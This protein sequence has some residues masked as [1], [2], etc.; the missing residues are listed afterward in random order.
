[1]S[2]EEAFVSVWQQAF[3]ENA[4]TVTLDDVSY[5][6][7]R[8]SRSKLREVDSSSGIQLSVGW[9]KTPAQTRGGQS[10]HERARRLCSFSWTAATLLGSSTA[11][12]RCITPRQRQE[13]NYFAASVTSL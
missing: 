8:T 2:L 5:P 12:L 3:A 1:M 4:K 6:I 11:K 9:S 13:V 7:R 10:W